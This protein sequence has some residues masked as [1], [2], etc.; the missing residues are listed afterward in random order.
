MS[1]DIHTKFL[2]VPNIDALTKINVS[3]KSI[4]FILGTGQIYT[5][6]KYFPNLDTVNTLNIATKSWTTTQLNNYLPLTGG[7]LTGVLQ[8]SNSGLKFADNAFGG[9][10]DTAKM[11]LATK[12]GEATTMTFEVGNDDDDTINFI[13]PSSTGLTHNS[14]IILDSLNCSDYAATT[15]YVNTAVNNI[16]IGGRNLILNSKISLS[17]TSYNVH[18]FN[19]SRLFVVG[20]T[21]TVTIKG[22]IPGSKLFGLWFNGSAFG[23]ASITKISDG[24]YSQVITVP[25]GTTNSSVGLY[26]KDNQ[27]VN[28]EWSFEWIK[29]ESGNKRTDWSPAPEDVD[30]N[31][32]TAQSTAISSAA[33][34]AASK[35][36]PLIGGNIS[37]VLNVAGNITGTLIG[38]ASTATNAGNANTVSG[39]SVASGRNNVGNQIVRTDG[40]G[41]LQTGYINSSNGDEGN[42]SNPIRVWGTNGSDSYLRT[43][44]T[45]ALNVG[46]ADTVDSF[47]ESSFLRYK[48][49]TLTTDQNTFDLTDLSVRYLYGF[50]AFD[51]EESYGLILNIGVGALSH[52]GGQFYLPRFGSHL[53]YRGRNDNEGASKYS[54]W[55]KLAWITDNVASATRLQTARSL[56]GN[57]YDGTGDINGCIH[58]KG[59][60]GGNFSEGIRI[61]KSSNNWATIILCGLDNTVD[62]GTSA[63]SWS[64]H[65][66]SG[67][68]FAIAHNDS[69]GV[70]GIYIRNSDS[71]IGLGTTS[72]AYKLD[73]SGSIIADSWLRTRGATGW[74]SET[75]GGGWYM[76]DTTWVRSY[77]NKN[78][79]TGGV[80]QADGGFNGNVNGILSHTGIGTTWVSGRDNALIRQT[81][82]NGYSV[83]LTTKTTNG[84]WELGNYTDYGEQLLLTYISDTI[85][86][87]NTNTISSQYQFPLKSGTV[88]LTSDI[89]TS[90]PANGGHADTADQVGTINVATPITWDKNYYPA[91]TSTNG[92][93]TLWKDSGTYIDNLGNFYVQNHK[94]VSIAYNNYITAP[95]TILKSIQVLN[96]STA[97]FSASNH[98]DVYIFKSGNC[99]LDIYNSDNYDG[100]EFT[101]YDNIGS[102]GYFRT[103]NC[104]FIISLDYPGT[105]TQDNNWHNLQR[106]G[107]WR[108]LYSAET[109]TWYI[110]RLG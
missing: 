45:S 25:T 53:E 5:H 103:N 81:T 108:F 3:D 71:F 91:L 67:N 90:L 49:Q 75:Y 46:N 102:N 28:D 12:G 36:L 79:F 101:I 95:V 78:V 74:Y 62:N 68:D 34:N 26:L 38:N 22:N 52:F 110:H 8:L 93:S 70:N 10:G 97:V 41:Y 77:S 17:G 64:I 60:T 20:E 59:I 105:Y 31:I 63:N 94:V 30:A 24:L 1:V 48:G 98:K 73:V 39:L 61:H 58:I 87:N 109:N 14:N 69:S 29:L 55:K 57:L 83:V 21:L 85:H 37:G 15:D 6:G 107:A 76:T 88:A 65:N 100:R 2:S 18:T 35:Y 44:L 99:Y 11:Y 106:D 4:V 72:P 104:G 66:T 13:T 92:P 96:N 33:T 50:N 40:N 27:S 56:W 7:T 51:F 9:G 80:M 19:A 43:Y 47:H 89:P 32:A 42:N 16:Q 82:A 86:T 84:S 23:T 54:E